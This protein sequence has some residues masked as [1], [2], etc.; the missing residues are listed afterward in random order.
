MSKSLEDLETKTSQVEC[1]G[2][3]GLVVAKI[4]VDGDLQFSLGFP[5][6]LELGLVVT[7]HDIEIFQQEI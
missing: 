7:R 2:A 5:F 1:K 6:E 4:V 3:V